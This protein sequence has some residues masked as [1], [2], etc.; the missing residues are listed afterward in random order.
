MA[1][2]LRGAHSTEMMTQKQDRLQWDRSY[3]CSCTC[4]VP[5]STRCLDSSRRTPS[6]RSGV[7]GCRLHSGRNSAY[8]WAKCAASPA[9]SA[10]RP[11]WVCLGPRLA[12]SHNS[13]AASC[14]WTS[15]RGRRRTTARPGSGAHAGRHSGS[16]LS[17]Q[18]IAPGLCSACWPDSSPTSPPR[19]PPGW[20]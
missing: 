17:A 14:P 4:L 7:S 3:N 13:L 18:G 8:C 5:G 11:G 19:R 6:G 20:S 1:A 2:S 12:G 16:G 10:W 9:R 15:W